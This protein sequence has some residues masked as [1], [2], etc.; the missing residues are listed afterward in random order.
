MEVASELMD[1]DD[2]GL[3]QQPGVACADYESKLDACHKLHL[4][5]IF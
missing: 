4:G 5:F 3:C 1:S 2:A